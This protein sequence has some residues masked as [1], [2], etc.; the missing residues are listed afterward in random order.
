MNYNGPRFTH[1]HGTTQMSSTSQYK[2]LFNGSYIS[3]PVYDHLFKLIIIG[4]SGVGKTCITL[5]FTDELFK[6]NF[7]H[8]LGVDFKI[9]TVDIKGKKIKLQI[10]DT[11][12]QERF[13]AVTTSHY[14]H[15]HGVILVYDITN[16]NSFL[17]IRK[18]LRNVEEFGR[19][20]AHLVLVGNKLDLE[21]QRE[22]TYNGGYQ[23]A[24]D[25]GMTFLEVSAKEA[26]NIDECFIVLVENILKKNPDDLRILNDIQNLATVKKKS[27]GHCNSK[28]C[29]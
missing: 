15:A 24:N 26:S 11:A 14:K 19:E 27:D 29:Y 13:H 18:W 7:T 21:S 23:L 9:K 22:V 12:G 8:T 20:G 4:E 28:I 10:W 6:L 16:Y 25:L 2:D 1:L 5:R 17:N 3:N